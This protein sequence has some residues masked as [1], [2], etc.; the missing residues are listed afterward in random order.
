MRLTHIKLAGFKSFSE[1][2][3]I[4]LP[5]QLAAVIGPNG[6]GKSNVIDAV[7]WVLGEASA[8]Q[9]RGEQMQD[10]IFNGA[11]T[12]RP[13]PRASVELIFDNSTG[14]LKNAW[15][16]Y[17][18]ISVKRQLNRQGESRYFINGQTVRRRDITDLFL[19]TGVGARGYAVIEQGII[20]RIIEARPEELRA[21]L[22]EAAGI[23]KYKERRRETEARLHDTREHLQRLADLQTELS[24]QVEKL[25]QQAAAATRHQNLSRE[26]NELQNLSDFIRWQQSLADADRADA[27]RHEAD[28]ARTATEEHIELLNNNLEQLRADE[29]QQQQQ[30]HH[31]NQEYTL[32]REQ[33]ARLEEQIRAEQ[34]QQ[35]R[36]SHEQ[37]AAAANLQRLHHES[38][39]LQ[40]QLQEAAALLSKQQIQLEEIRLIADEYETRLPESEEALHTAEESLRQAAQDWQAAANQAA[41][42]EQN[43]RHLQHNLLRHSEQHDRL[44][45]ELAALPENSDTDAAVCHADSLQQQYQAAETLLAEYAHSL[46]RHR[47]SHDEAAR[48]LHLLQQQQLALQTKQHTLAELI[49]ARH[50]DDFWQHTG[51]ADR[52][53]LHPQLLIQA[54][55]QQAVALILDKRLH[56]R[57][58]PEPFTP[59]HP[60]PQGAAAWVCPSESAPSEPHPHAL[61]RQI[62]APDAF[63]PAL[64][65]W[66]ADALCAPDLHTALQ[67][68]HRLQG[69][70]YWLTPEGHRIDRHSVLLHDPSR[71]TDNSAV[72]TLEHDRLDR[73]LA[74][75]APHI[76]TAE[77]K[78]QRQQQQ[79]EQLQ[80]QYRQQQTRQQQLYG[81][82]L[83]AR[84]HA[85][86]LLAQ[87]QH[88]LLRRRQLQDELAAL[89]AQ[90][91]ELQQNLEYEQQQTEARQLQADSLKQHNGEL[92]ETCKQL[93][94]QWQ[95]CRS[96]REQ[97]VSRQNTAE[98]K[99]Q[100]QQQHL[101]HLQQQHTHL[102]QQQQEWQTR[103]NELDLAADHS[104]QYEEHLHR[105]EQLNEQTDTL[106]E[107]IHN[108]E[109]R[110]EDIRHR[111]RNLQTE[112]QQQQNR[113]PE[114]HSAAQ[115]ALLQQQEALL[116]A[117]HSHA[118]LTARHADLDALAHSAVHADSLNGLNRRINRT[119]Q[120]LAALGAVNLAALQELE[121]AAERDAY[122]RRQ[123][124]DIQAAVSLLEDAVAQIDAES[125]SRFQHTFNAVNE[126]MQSLFPTLFG[127]GEAALQLSSDDAL[128]AGVT[129]TAR[130]PGKK[131]STI[132]LLSG[133]EKALT[134]M[135]FV[136]AL[137][138]LNPAP[139]C[140][141][142]EVDAPLD[143]A[144]T[145]RFCRLVKEMSAHTQFLYISHNRLTMEMAE[146]LIGVTMQEKGVSRI[147][148]VDIKQALNLSGQ[149]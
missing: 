148:A 3:T 115:N 147:V 2:A 47:H 97:A 33:S 63:L 52:P 46:Q 27:R 76:Q 138:S 142:D 40:Q 137:F 96:N 74:A 105:L 50:N 141:L 128:N 119:R 79:L 107:H 116:Q 111:Y 53:V 120:D 90:I 11:A 23:S 139:F 108:T 95:H 51:H 118:E 66:L 35:Q 145:A 25:Q 20:S 88:K 104:L 146:Q 73:E 30:R 9:L 110:L 14:S 17:Q 45:Q 123:S 84:R 62:Q 114:L 92:D 7:R 91:H 6:C 49:R 5:G 82:H 56:S 98:L 34:Q 112:Q 31:L 42:S 125:K 117:K 69:Q 37:N 136:F 22:E 55:W 101:H 38:T 57:S 103:Q 94:Q 86:S 87:Q 1:P 8:K 12:R 48:A 72:H 144:N 135:S 26:L 36:I 129:I 133:G 28:A 58:L 67:Q 39:Q 54:E 89:Q 113:L 85:D 78:L 71:D 93:R 81:E 70:Q 10:V 83:A 131:N 122:Y 68:Q 24:R 13:A 134:A 121:E 64:Q 29:Q 102:Q 59:P 77:Q 32:L 16:R 99:L 41:L 143:D 140:L 75:L 80:Q 126:K 132:H 106:R 18:E 44:Q 149:E 60:L 61:I 130:P 21:H 109:S 65:H 19:G 124:E 4:R 127:G 43:L 100:Q 15:G